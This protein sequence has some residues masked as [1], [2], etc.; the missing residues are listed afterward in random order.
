MSERRLA[1]AYPP[2]PANLPARNPR[3]AI[4]PMT[5]LTFSAVRIHQII[6]AKSEQRLENA[7][8]LDPANPPARNPHLATVPMTLLMFNAAHPANHFSSSLKANEEDL[9]LESLTKNLR[10]SLFV[11]WH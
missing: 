4:V 7:Y 11:F 8:L 6:H 10:L 3:L 9:R 5:L 2:D 1:N